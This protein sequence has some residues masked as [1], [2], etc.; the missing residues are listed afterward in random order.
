M[1]RSFLF[2]PADWRQE[3]LYFAREAVLRTYVPTEGLAG[4]ASIFSPHVS[5]SKLLDRAGK[6]VRTYNQVLVH[7]H[8]QQQG[9][10]QHVKTR[11]HG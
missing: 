6:V 4:R 2:F 1:E 9:L 11:N 3:G 8:R 5:P 7:L 10:Q